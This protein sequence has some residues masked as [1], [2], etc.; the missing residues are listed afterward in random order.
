MSKSIK[1]RVRKVDVDKLSP[2]Q[3]EQ[4]GFEMGKKIGKLCDQTAEDL[5]KKVNKIT[6]IYG[7]TAFVQIGF[8]DQKGNIIE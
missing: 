1:E 8:K 4:I 2:E 3:Q 6:G 5:T 7:L